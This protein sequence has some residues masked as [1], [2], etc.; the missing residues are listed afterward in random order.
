M[1]LCG[2]S[3][4]ILRVNLESGD[5]GIEQPDEGYYQRYLGG[6]GIIMHTLLKEVPAK[7]DP[8]GPE[9]GDHHV[10]RG[11]NWAQ[12]TI[13]EL[14]LSYRDYGDKARNSV[15]LRIARYVEPVDEKAQ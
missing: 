13:T 6:R 8:L 14:R 7:A 1:D 10:I 2:Y 11:P 12:G 3:G 9:K 15:G 5:I 4:K